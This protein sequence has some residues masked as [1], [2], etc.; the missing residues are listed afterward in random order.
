[1]KN[2]LYFLVLVLLLASCS[3]QKEPVFIKV[4][5]VTVLSFATDTIKLKATAFFENPNDVGGKISTDSIKIF[6]NN[7][8]VAQVFS[9]EFKVPAKAAFSI[10]MTAHIATKNIL[11]SNKNGVLGGLLNSL[12]TN[13]VN[14]RI[15]GNLEYVVFGFKRDFLIDKTEEIKIKL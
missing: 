15:K 3:I 12:L 1:M 10:P 4:D 9:E 14:I 6:V 11:N 13:K 8:E 2:K 7:V 5:N